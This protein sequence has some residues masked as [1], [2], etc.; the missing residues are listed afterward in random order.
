LR[1]SRKGL[2]GEVVVKAAGVVNVF[3]NV[4]DV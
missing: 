3:E 4:S 1:I 2:V